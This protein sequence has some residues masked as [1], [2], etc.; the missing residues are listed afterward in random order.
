MER[1]G[2]PLQREVDVSTLCNKHCTSRSL[3]VPSPNHT[4]K[5]KKPASCSNKHCDTFYPAELDV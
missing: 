2:G 5:T 3:D 1:V 4:H